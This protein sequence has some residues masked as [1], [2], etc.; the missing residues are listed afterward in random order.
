MVTGDSAVAVVL[1]ALWALIG[2]L[3]FDYRELFRRVSRQDLYAWCRTLLRRRSQDSARDDRVSD[4]VHTVRGESRLDA[5]QLGELA[6]VTCH[7]NPAGWDTTRQNYVRFVSEMRAQ[8]VSLFAAEVAF[9][10]QS[11]IFSDAHLR[12]R[13]ADDCIV[14][15]KERLFNRVVETLPAHYGAIALVDADIIFFDPHWV[16]KALKQLCEVSI[17]QL[18]DRLHR[19]D[20][21]GRVASTYSGTH[22]MPDTGRRLSYGRSSLLPW[23]GGA[24]AVRR[25]VFPLYDRCIL[26]GGDVANLEGWLGLRDT[27]LQHQMTPAEKVYFDSW[28]SAA[29]FRVDGRCKSLHG[30]CAHLYHG[31]TRGRRYAERHVAARV[32]N[33]D[34]QRHIEVDE[35]GLLRWT[36][37]SPEGLRSY[38]ERYFCSRQEDG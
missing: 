7:F 9:P 21:D 37:C 35:N 28:A 17:V 18:F 26:G 20:R 3:I 19:L 5:A 15:Q 13:A 23:Q 24:W 30:G 8:G 12:I 22:V 33:F 25:S 36:A 29:A 6:V 27:W 38:V 4:S 14:W 10:G 34:P 11:F 32:F 31:S 1:G 2:Y 16:E